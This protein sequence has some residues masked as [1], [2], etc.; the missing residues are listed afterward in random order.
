MTFPTMSKTPQLDLQ[1]EREPVL[2]ESPTVE[3]LQSVVPLSVPG[4]GVPAAAPCHPWF[5]SNRFPE[6]RHA[7]F[8]WNQVRHALGFTPGIDTA[9]TPGDGG[10]DPRTGVQLPSFGKFAG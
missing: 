6:S 7:W 8:A 5:V 1:L 2:T 10:F 9:Y 4:S 3:M